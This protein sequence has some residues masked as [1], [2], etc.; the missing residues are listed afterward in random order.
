MLFFF[1]SSRRRHTRYI[2]V[3]G[4][5][6]C[7]LPIWINVQ[8]IDAETDEHLWAEIYDRQ[9]SAEN[10]FA[11]QSEISQA[12]AAA[13]KATLSPEEQQRINTVPTDNLAA[14]DA[15]LRGRQLMATRDSTKLKLATEAFTEAVELDPQF[16]LAWVNLADSTF[17][18]AGYGT[19]SNDISLPIRINAI[20]RAMAIDDQLGEAYASLA[21]IHEDHFR[22]AEAETA[23]QK[24]IELSP[25]YATAYHWYS[26]FLNRFPLRV[27]ETIALA[28]KAAE[29]DPGSSIIGV[30]LA[31]AYAERGLYSLAERQFQKVMQLDPEFVQAFIAM[32]NLNT[33][34]LGKFDIGVEYALKASRMDP[35]NISNLAL[36]SAAYTQLGNLAL[37]EATLREMEALD[38]NHLWTA[39]ISVISSAYR[40]NPAG[41]RETINWAIPKL[42]Y[43]PGFIMV[44]A[45]IELGLGDAQRAREI[46]LSAHPGWLEPD[47][48]EQLIG[49]FT[50]SACIVSWLLIKTG[51][52]Q[53]GTALLARTTT[54]LDE[55]LPAVMEHTDRYSPEICYLTA[56]DTDKA[57]FSL[58]TQLAHNHLFGWDLRHTLPMYDL[59]RDEP[60]Y[61]AML[62][63]RERRIA[64]QREAVAKMDTG[65]GL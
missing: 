64:V 8:L 58:A 7:A 40:D 17:L 19:L 44:M 28:Q 25:N 32:A 27:Q 36:L 29:L 23:L 57:L 31:G 18:L 11:I 52:A 63:E 21:Q 2:S 53:P 51:D 12:I 16:A 33:F 13:L 35:G 61:L 50:S 46:Y 9:L 39:F 1:F 42:E 20:E 30:N 41:I 45:D 22:Y 4:V 65:A 5:Q 34:T 15:Y 43:V 24:S 49:Q 54:Y 62:A 56:G 3:T 10:L 48:W 37:H 14:Y 55:A 47:Q 6:T 26:N 59:I 60:R 38:P